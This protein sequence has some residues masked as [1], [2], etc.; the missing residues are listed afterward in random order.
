MFMQMGMNVAVWK[1]KSDSTIKKKH[2]RKGKKGRSAFALTGTSC[3]EVTLGLLKNS[4]D[5]EEMRQ[6]WSW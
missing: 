4:L 3:D 2:C 6:Q 1:A 5:K